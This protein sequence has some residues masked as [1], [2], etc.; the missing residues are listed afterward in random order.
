ML[1]ET[2]NR[3]FKSQ[4]SANRCCERFEIVW[5]TANPEGAKRSRG[6]RSAPGAEESPE[7]VPDTGGRNDQGVGGIALSRL[8]NGGQRTV[9]NGLRVAIDTRVAQQDRIDEWRNVNLACV[10]WSS[11]GGCALIYKAPSGSG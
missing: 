8:R 1:P 10:K 11:A 5:G 9:K 6:P 2:A 7:A 3:W 4:I